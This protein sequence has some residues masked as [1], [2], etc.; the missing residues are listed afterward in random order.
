MTF[1]VMSLEQR[2]TNLENNFKIITT[3]VNNISQNTSKLNENIKEIQTVNSKL[4]NL[5]RIIDTKKSQ[6][7]NINSQNN[8]NEIN[9]PNFVNNPFIE[10]ASAKEEMITDS[11]EENEKSSNSMDISENNKKKRKKYK[12]RDPLYFYYEI[13]GKV[14]KYTCKNKYRKNIWVLNVPLRIVKH[15]GYIIKIKMNLNLISLLLTFLMMIIVIL[16]IIYMRINL[17]KWAFR[18]CFQKWKYKKKLGQYF[19]FLFYEDPNVTP[20][21]VKDKFSNRFPNIEISSKELD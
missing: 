5:L 6:N 13:E 11:E 15:K 9:N 17:K 20:T 3:N 18:R 2:I 7:N 21:Q 1:T 14:Y 16:L 8:I 10:E 19:K 4:D 12:I